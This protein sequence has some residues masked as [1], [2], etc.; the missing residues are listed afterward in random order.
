ML[1]YSLYI[2]IYI[3]IQSI[4]VYIYI[5]VYVY[6]NG[7]LY[8]FLH[9]YLY[10]YIFIYISTYLSLSLFICTC[11]LL[12][13]NPHEETYLGANFKQLQVRGS[14]LADR[15][16]AETD[17]WELHGFFVREQQG[18]GRGPGGPCTRKGWLWLDLNQN[19][20]VEPQLFRT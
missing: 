8:L 3:Y 1:I 20:A 4:Y 5:Y 2:Y 19:L 11:T 14:P 15:C 12:A 17:G 6:V 10:L 7:Y 18:D 13:W 16:T 9:L